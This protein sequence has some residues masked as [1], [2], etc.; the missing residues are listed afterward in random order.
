MYVDPP[1]LKRS[2][3]AVLGRAVIRRAQ[4]DRTDAAAQ[5][6]ILDGELRHRRSREIGDTSPSLPKL[7]AIAEAPPSPEGVTVTAEA[8]AVQIDDLTARMKGTSN[9]YHR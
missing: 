8:E 5:L 3:G 4:A 6:P 2:S 9:D 1:Y 7:H